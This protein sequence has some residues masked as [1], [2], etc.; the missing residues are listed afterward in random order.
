[1]SSRFQYLRVV[2]FFCG[3]AI[4]APHYNLPVFYAIPYKAMLM[5]FSFFMSAPRACFYYLTSGIDAKLSVFLVH[6]L[7]LN[8]SATNTSLSSC[9]LYLAAVIKGSIFPVMLVCMF[10]FGYE[11]HAIWASFF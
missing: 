2:S 11:F 5:P 7:F 10:P 9:A 8:F 6:F 4:C 1:L 3:S